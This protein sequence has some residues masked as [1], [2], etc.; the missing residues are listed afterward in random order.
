MIWA[1]QDS[2]HEA[3]PSRR[4]CVDSLKSQEPFRIDYLN[5]DKQAVASDDSVKY[6]GT[7]VRVPIVFSVPIERF[8]G[9]YLPPATHIL[10][11][12]ERTDYFPI[13]GARKNSH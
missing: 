10:H 5:R 11:Y 3:F 13:R 9:W 2:K 12:A 7:W 1:A 4:M 6:P 8:C